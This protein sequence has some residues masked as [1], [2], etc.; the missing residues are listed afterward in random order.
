MGLLV[1][2]KMSIV[3][4]L[5]FSLLW[6][7]TMAITILIPC[8]R[9]DKI[10]LISA[11]NDREK[12]GTAIVSRRF[13]LKKL[14]L[15]LSIRSLVSAK[16]HYISVCIIS[17]FLSLFGGIVLDMNGWL[18]TNGEGL[19]NAFS[20]ADHDI[21]FQPKAAVDMSEV[22]NIINQYDSI[23][24]IYGLAMQSAAINGSDCTAN[25]IDNVDKFHIISGRKPSNPNEIVITKTIS[26]SL[27]IS[28][29]DNV[30]VDSKGNSAVFHISG[31]YQCAN[32]MGANIGM[33][34]QGYQRLAD[35]D[36]YIWCYH[37]ILKD[38]SRN[39]EILSALQERFKLQA[40]IHTNSWSGLSGIV[41]TMRLLTMFM[42][43]VSAVFIFAA[44]SLQG[45]KMLIREQKDMAILKSLGITS[46]QLRI[47][48]A[49]RIGLSAFIGASL[50]GVVCVL[51]ADCI[52]SKIMALFGIGEFISKN[53]VI[54]AMLSAL[55][56][57][58]LFSLFAYIYS[59]RIKTIPITLLTSRT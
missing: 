52:I 58:L 7:G 23:S 22:E 10:T 56:V 32:E 51:S 35:T 42:L 13:A 15:S 45:G 25:I 29:G 28:V 49:L 37:Y 34:E 39:E 11:M 48:F 57:S 6:L 36:G 1:P 14:T 47:S 44:V 53:G 54:L 50:G 27:N 20:A 55:S 4:I 24:E 8:M 26:E 18:G 33:S 2:A 43:A 30:T 46:N 21:G 9:L 59:R 38:G 41:S 3:F 40:D 12:G 5:V 19:M 16:R 17:A 31:I